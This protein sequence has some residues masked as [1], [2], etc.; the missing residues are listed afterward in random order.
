MKHNRLQDNDYITD[1]QSIMNYGKHGK[2]DENRER[3]MHKVS[4]ADVFMQGKILHLV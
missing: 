2:H 4:F 3:R 1:I